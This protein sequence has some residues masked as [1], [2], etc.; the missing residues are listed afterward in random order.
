MPKEFLKLNPVYGDTEYVYVLGESITKAKFNGDKVLQAFAAKIEHMIRKQNF[1]FLNEE[2]LEADAKTRGFQFK[3]RMIASGDRAY[4]FSD[5]N[6]VFYMYENPIGKEVTFTTAT[7]ESGIFQSQIK[8]N[9][10]IEGTIV[11]FK[12]EKWV[13]SSMLKG[14]K[15]L[16]RLVELQIMTKEKQLKIFKQKGNNLKVLYETNA[17]GKV[18]DGDR[19]LYTLN[20]TWSTRLDK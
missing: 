11:D 3:N 20:A 15:T 19:Y 10:E 8:E 14:Q 18:I 5:P 17:D 9:D 2:A 6:M 12:M 4:Y 16:V 13:R 1:D 7:E